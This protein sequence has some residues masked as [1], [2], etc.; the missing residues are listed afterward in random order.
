MKEARPTSDDDA[1]EE[2]CYAQQG[3]QEGGPATDGSSPPASPRVPKTAED[4]DAR[5]K[6]SG[7]R[8]SELPHL[9][10]FGVS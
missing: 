2:S 10:V 5:T 7:L 1:G 4:P 9:C 6:A 3:S 8:A